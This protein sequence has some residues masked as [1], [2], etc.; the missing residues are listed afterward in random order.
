MEF[1]HACAKDVA[2]D[3]LNVFMAMLK[4][5]ETSA[6]IN[7]RQITLIPKSV[8]NLGWEAGDRSPFWAA[9]RKSSR[10]FLQGDYKGCSPT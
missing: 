3:L 1:F 8:T 9:C 7:R 5:G 6:F 2:P 4:E 10:K